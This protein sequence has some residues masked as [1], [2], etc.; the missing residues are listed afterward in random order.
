VGRSFDAFGG[1]SQGFLYSGGSFSPI[2][3]PGAE[4]TEAYGINNAGQIVGAYGVASDPGHYLGFLYSGGHFTTIHFPG[5]TF[6]GT[7]AL[8]INDAGV[9]VGFTG[10]LGEPVH[11]GILNS[12]GTFTIINP[13]PPAIGLR[14]TGINDAGRSWEHLSSPRR[15]ASLNL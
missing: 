15:P 6:A 2:N 7:D 10:F 11:Q 14:A 5:G 1:H 13:V 3:V 9:I 12:E 8:G 4:F